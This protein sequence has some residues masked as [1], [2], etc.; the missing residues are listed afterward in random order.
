MHLDPYAR[1]QLKAR[2]HALID[3]AT[4]EFDRSAI[5]RAEWQEQVAAVLAE[6]YLADDDPRW[7]SGFDGDESLWR[8]ARSLVLLAAPASG[9]FLDVGCAN[10]YL[11]Q[12]LACWAPERSQDLEL[13]GLELNASLAAAARLRLPQL[14]ARVFTGNISDWHPPRRFDCVRVGLEYVPHG[15]E[16]TLLDRIARDVLTEDGRVLVGPINDDA[17][18]ATRCA[19]DEVGLSNSGVVSET[20]HRGKTR[21]VVWCAR[22]PAR[23]SG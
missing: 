20:D 4:E 19:F 8:E 17:V 1:V 2:A 16:F 7:Q 5:T 21:H 3:A 9:T 12:S 22:H 10:G 23:D 14:A 11:L 18:S 6:A 13:Y 15:E